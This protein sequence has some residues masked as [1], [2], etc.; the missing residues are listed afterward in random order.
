MITG[1]RAVQQSFYWEVKGMETQGRVTIIIPVYNSIRYLR[2]TIDSVI[3]QSYSN[4][5]VIIVDDGST[6]GSADICD[7]YA[8]TDE[9]FHNTSREQRIK[10]SS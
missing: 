2:E 6:D 7:E 9:R 5:E 10:L 8:Q 3:H 4:I 1:S